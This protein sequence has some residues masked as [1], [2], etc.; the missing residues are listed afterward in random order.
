MVGY[1]TYLQNLG[2][3]FKFGLCHVSNGK[4]LYTVSV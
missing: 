3:K 4:N 1:S 2:F